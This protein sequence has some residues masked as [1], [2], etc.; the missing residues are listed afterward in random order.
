[1]R[2]FN[3]PMLCHSIQPHT[4]LLQDIPDYVADIYKDTIPPQEDFTTTTVHTKE[5]TDTN[6][7]PEIKPAEL[8]SKVL[9]TVLEKESAYFIALY[10]QKPKP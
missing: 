1:M 8:S 2:L 5:P 10:E 9:G 7:D 6:L 4:Q 3:L